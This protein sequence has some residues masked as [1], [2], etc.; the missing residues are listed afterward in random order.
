LCLSHASAWMCNA[1]FH[2]RFAMFI[3]WKWQVI[4]RFADIK[5][6]VEDYRNSTLIHTQSSVDKRYCCN[7]L[8]NFYNKTYSFEFLLLSVVSFNID[9]WPFNTSNYTG[10]FD[11][12]YVLLIYSQNKN[13]HILQSCAKN[14]IKTI[15][16]YSRVP[17]TK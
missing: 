7:V 9:Q 13:H 15:I 12:K 4:V 10:R 2:G 17:K 11:Y 14:K 8:I 1:I 5:R 16:S 3:E 6:E